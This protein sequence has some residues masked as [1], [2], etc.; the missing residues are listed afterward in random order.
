MI[1]LLIAMI[2]IWSIWDHVLCG[3]TVL[4]ISKLRLSVCDFNARFFYIT[5][6]KNIHKNYIIRIEGRIRKR[7][8]S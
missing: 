5:C 6:L 2:D 8:F 3:I 4:F 1:A 7:D